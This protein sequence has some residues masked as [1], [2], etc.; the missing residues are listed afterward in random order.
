LNKRELA[1]EL[2]ERLEIDKRTALQFVDEFITTITDTVASGEPVVLTGFAKFVRVQRGARMARNPM[3]GAAVKVPAK[4][5]ARITALKAFKDAV[6]AGKKAPAKKAVAKKAPAKKKAVA[7]KA[8]AK[9]VVAKKTV[10][11]KAPAKK[12]VTKKTVAKKAPAK[13]VVAK[14]T[15]ARKAPAKKKATA[16]R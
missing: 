16:R 9:K 14:K 10:A 13:K 3:T 7:K 15:V 11:K 1:A 4:K 6:V 8:P 2:A 12:V 5:A